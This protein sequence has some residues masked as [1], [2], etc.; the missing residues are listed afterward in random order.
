MSPKLKVGL[1]V[2]GAILTLFVLGWFLGGDDS[3]TQSQPEVNMPQ[4]AATPGTIPGCVPVTA[5]R[6]QLPTQVAQP[7]F[8]FKQS[9]QP[10][11]IPE[12][13]ELQRVGEGVKKIPIIGDLWKGLAVVFE[14]LRCILSNIW[15]ILVLAL[16]ASFLLRVP[17]WVPFTIT[18][19]LLQTLWSKKTAKDVWGHHKDKFNDDKKKS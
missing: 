13:S 3:S 4:A 7:A 16:A 14:S 18:W 11:P 1:V 12:R 9:T 5:K 19:E 8:Q 2:G 15:L 6:C 10:T 17:V